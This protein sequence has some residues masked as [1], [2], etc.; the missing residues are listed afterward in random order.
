MSNAMYPYSTH[1]YVVYLYA[2][3]VYTHICITH[4]H[5]LPDVHIL[6][7][8]MLYRYMYVYSTHI[9][10]LLTHISKTMCTHSTHVYA[11]CIYPNHAYEHTYIY[12]NQRITAGRQSGRLQGRH[13]PKS[14]RYSIYYIECLGWL[15]RKSMR[16]IYYVK[17]LR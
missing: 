6:L 16:H 12:I 1:T 15:L 2:H 5:E 8:Y 13:S 3:I 17:C 7:T 10:A 14:S 9:Y 4:I 11:M